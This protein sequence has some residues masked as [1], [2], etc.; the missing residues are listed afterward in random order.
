[1]DGNDSYLSGWNILACI[2]MTV[3]III[4]VL[5]VA[6]QTCRMLRFALTVRS[7][8]FA[9]SVI[10]LYKFMLSVLRQCNASCITVRAL[11]HSKQ[12]QYTGLGRCN[13]GNG[14]GKLLES[15]QINYLGQIEATRHTSLHNRIIASCPFEILSTRKKQNLFE[16][17]FLKLIITQNVFIRTD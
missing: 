12:P 5:V 10:I 15:L 8:R 4:S 14:N 13:S 7:S 16:V 17:P 2:Y 11:N 6:S 3:G 9:R 1:M